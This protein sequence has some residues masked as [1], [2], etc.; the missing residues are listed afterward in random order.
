MQLFVLLVLFFSSFSMAHEILSSTQ[1][2]NLRRQ[3][4]TGLQQ[5][6]LGKMEISR[7]V[8]AGLQGTYLKRFDFYEK[9]A[10]AFLVYRPAER[11]TIETKY[12][13]GIGSNEILPERQYYFSAWYSLGEGLSPFLHYRGSEYSVTDLQTVAAGMEIEKIENLIFIPSVMKGKATFRNAADTEDVYSY[14]MRIIYYKEGLYSFSVFSYKGQEASQG[15]IAR[16]SILVDTFSG[17]LSASYFVRK[18]LKAE[19]VFDHTDYDQ[20]RTEFHTTTL[21]LTWMF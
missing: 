20:L 2:I 16:S 7:K 14:G 12:L 9:A 18:D 5:D 21:N 11:W 8:S 13:H 19:L 6:L 4:Q 1:I 17:G 3:N 10:G 15:I